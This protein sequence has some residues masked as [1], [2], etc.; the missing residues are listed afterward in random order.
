[1]AS[2]FKTFF[3]GILYIVL[4]PFIALLLAIYFVYC[5]VVFLYMGV[6]CIIVFFAGGSP[7]G[8]LPE[9]V[10]AKEILATQAQNLV[11]Q[12]QTYQQYPSFNRTQQPYNQDPYVEPTNVA[13]DNQ[14]NEFDENKNSDST[15]EEEPFND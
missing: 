1:M 13:V 4:L 3:K 8:D 6:R 11:L 9:D 5:L 12:Q 10:K 2:F 15:S 7:L 14:I